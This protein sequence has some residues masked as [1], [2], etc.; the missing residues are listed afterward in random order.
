[1]VP[2]VI[3]ARPDLELVLA[4]AQRAAVLLARRMREALVDG[5]LVPRQ[6]VLGAEAVVAAAAA[7]LGAEEGLGVSLVVFSGPTVSFPSQQAGSSG[8]L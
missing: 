7:R 4:P 5:A 8:L 3:S 1:M 2:E 6:V